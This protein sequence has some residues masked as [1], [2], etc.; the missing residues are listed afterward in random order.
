[1]AGAETKA[2]TRPEQEVPYLA[3]AQILVPFFVCLY[4]F[5]LGV[6][7]QNFILSLVF[8]LAMS[9]LI[10]WAVNP[11]RKT[12]S[13][14][15]AMVLATGLALAYVLWN[16][17]A[18]WLNQAANPA[19]RPA[20]FIAGHLGWV[21]LPVI[22]GMSGRY[23]N[24]RH[25][26][27]LAA[28]TA[29]LVC[30][31]AMVALSQSIWGWRIRGIS[32]APDQ[33]RPRGFYSHPLT[34]A[35]ASLLVFAPALR[36]LFR[37]PGNRSLWFIL[38]GAMLL[39]YLT[40]SRMVQGTA[41]LLL[42]WNLLTRL[43]GRSRLLAVATLLILGIVAG[44]TENRLSSKFRSMFSEEGFDR[45]TTAYADDRL[46]F[47]DVHWDMIKDRPL[48][49]HGPH[50]RTAYRSTW[51]EKKGLGEFPKK[52]E[53]HN[54]WLQILTNSGGIGLALFLCWIFSLLLLIRSTYLQPWQRS[55]FLQTLLAF[56]FSGFTQNNLQDAEV[57]YG[58][59][60][61][62][63]LLFVLC[64]QQQRSRESQA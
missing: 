55:L 13:L 47:W 53:A 14:P 27:W 31:W 62:C 17:T 22:L 52:Y 4:A 11:A 44:S 30:A 36:A 12:A 33:L 38:A 39:V 37:F 18:G 35:Y 19:A 49:G 7:G 59:T 61:I 15:P 8:L 10:Q 43:R 28:G 64:L 57:R 2:V 23:L 3:R 21:F 32:F 51:Y 56:L 41:L 48:T 42:G 29:V 9:R 20:A 46:V 6:A 5:P 25:W 60:L 63:S 26:Q 34:L 24:Q 45:Q 1:M 40:E 54:I 50:I 16:A 58:F